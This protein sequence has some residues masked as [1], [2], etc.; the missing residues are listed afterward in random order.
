MVFDASENHEDIVFHLDTPEGI[1]ELTSSG[2]S[3]KEGCKYK[4]RISFRV[5]HEI[6]AGIKFVNSVKKAVF[7]DTEDLMIGSY[8][9]ASTPHVFEFPR[10]GFMDAP[11]GM[12]YRGK[13]HCKNQF[14]D[15]DG[16][17]HLQY[18]YEV[19]IKK[20]WTA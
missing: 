14:I 5:Q 1:A 9:P 17:N 4:F 20:D 18:E 10:Y 7:T 19:Q 6:V 16:V 11:K 3:M 2:I 15:S 13:Y 12:I 8:P